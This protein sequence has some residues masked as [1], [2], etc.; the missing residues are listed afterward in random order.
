MFRRISTTP[1]SITYILG[2]SRNILIWFFALDP[3]L[4]YEKN[5]IL[6]IIFHSA[7]IAVGGEQKVTLHPVYIYT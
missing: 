7:T 6:H 4:N 5:D 3:Q 1:D 2:I